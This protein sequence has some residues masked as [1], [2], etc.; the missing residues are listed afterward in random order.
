MLKKSNLFSLNKG[1]V[2]G[3]ILFI[4]LTTILLY[5]SNN[6]LSLVG[7]RNI[8]IIEITVYFAYMII[9][10]Y[11]LTVIEDIGKHLI[12]YLKPNHRPTY[13]VV[14]YAF[15]LIPFLELST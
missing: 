8:L 14:C 10:N 12:T 6:E 2:K 9:V 7:I 13:K 11:F 1:L 4:I 15:F 5:F 3:G